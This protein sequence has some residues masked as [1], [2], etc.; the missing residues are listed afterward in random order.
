MPKEVKYIYQDCAMCGSRAGW[1]K[2]QYQIAHRYGLTIKKTPFFTPGADGLMWK[3]VESGIK[4]YPFYTDGVKFSKNIEDFVEKPK[5]KRKYRK[6]KE[7]KIED[8]IVSKD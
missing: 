5:T 3:A 7:G 6:K 8:G 4:S 1:A 2:Q